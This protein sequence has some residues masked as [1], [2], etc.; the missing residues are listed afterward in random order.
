MVITSPTPERRARQSTRK[1]HAAGDNFPV[2]VPGIPTASGNGN[3]E[4]RRFFASKSTC[5][6]RRGAG[7]LRKRQA[8][9]PHS[10]V[11]P[12]RSIRSSRPLNRAAVA[13]SGGQGWPLLQRPP[14][15]LQPGPGL[16]GREH[17]GTLQRTGCRRSQ[18]HS[19]GQNATI[20]KLARR[21]IKERE[22]AYTLI[23][24]SLAKLVARAIAGRR[25]MSNPLSIK[26]ANTMRLKRS[27][28]I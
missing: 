4:R 7:R 14:R 23:G 6:S 1:M 5:R 15:R 10:I 26:V 24:A 21:A 13:R 27:G 12:Q 2:P 25:S 8:S 17:D 19:R 22:R 9:M 18:T 28:A 3:W 20:K 16:D 11:R